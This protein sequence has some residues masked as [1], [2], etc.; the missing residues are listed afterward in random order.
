MDEGL[1]M[2]APERMVIATEYLHFRDFVITT[3]AALP[4]NACAKA[5]LSVVEKYVTKEEKFENLSIK[6]QSNAATRITR[7]CVD[8]NVQ[9]SVLSFEDV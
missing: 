7:L 2:S 5:V 8:A 9:E 1:S 3:G 6:S 4:I